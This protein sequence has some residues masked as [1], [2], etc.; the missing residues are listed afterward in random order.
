MQVKKF[1]VDYDVDNRKKYT[2]TFINRVDEDTIVLL[3]DHVY[4]IHDDKRVILKVIKTSAVDTITTKLTATLQH[5][6]KD[7]DSFRNK[8]I[9][10]REWVF[11]TVYK[12]E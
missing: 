8:K 11:D 9:N 10:P 4:I 1:K 12:H 3:G 5:G 2:I 7:Y 6:M